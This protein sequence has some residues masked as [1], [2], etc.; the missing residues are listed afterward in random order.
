MSINVVPIH[1]RKLL[2]EKKEFREKKK[3]R[4]INK[5]RGILEI[6]QFGVSAIIMSTRQP[7]SNLICNNKR[8]AKKGK[9][10]I[11]NDPSLNS[12]WSITF[13]LFLVTSSSPLFRKI[14]GCQ[15]KYTVRIHRSIDLYQHYGWILSFSPSCYTFSLVFFSPQH[16]HYFS[17]KQEKLVQTETDETKT[18]RWLEE[19]GDRGWESV[20]WFIWS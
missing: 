7:N 5:S 20:S 17:K 9:T 10:M 11:Q 16:F 13:P 19:G 8:K 12:S 6:D 14:A 2:W 18:T 1:L 3:R 4:K 15:V